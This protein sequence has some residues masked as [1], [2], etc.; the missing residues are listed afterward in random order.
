[1]SNIHESGLFHAMICLVLT[2]N[3]TWIL[4]I[5]MLWRPPVV[6]AISI[7]VTD[8]ADFLQI[9]DMLCAMAFH[10]HTKIHFEQKWSCVYMLHSMHTLSIKNALVKCS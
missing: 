10:P 7:V 3:D 8:L 4:C 6:I 9:A 2:F 1:M 5:A